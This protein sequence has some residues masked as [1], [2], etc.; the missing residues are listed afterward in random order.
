MAQVLSPQERD[1]HAL[2]ELKARFSGEATATELGNALISQAVSGNPKSFQ[3]LIKRGAEC[4][5]HREDGANALMISAAKLPVPPDLEE[6]ARFAKEFPGAKTVPWKWEE[7]HYQAVERTFEAAL[8]CTKDIDAKDGKGSAV[9]HYAAFRRRFDAVIRL[10]LK[11]ANVNAPDGNGDVVIM[12]AATADLASLVKC[13]A[14]I[15]AVDQRGR[16][17]LHRAFGMPV[18]PKLVRYV[19]TAIG[20]GARDSQDSRGEFA[21]E[22]DG[23]L[24]LVTSPEGFARAIEQLDQTRKLIRATRPG[25]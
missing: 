13:G 8:S 15:N 20:L 17:V 24:P 16:T 3:W 9:V 7:Q 22:M 21:S 18:G 5:F 6:E 23:D 4:D 1:E 11:G 12:S 2:V 19:I 10:A 14:N 25:G